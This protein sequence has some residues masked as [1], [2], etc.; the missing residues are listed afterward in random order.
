M[1]ATIADSDL[2]R[3]NRNAGKEAVVVYPELLDLVEKALAYAKLSDGAFN[4]AIGPLL[5]LWG[6]GTDEARVPSDEEIR[7]TLPL[8]SWK[9]VQVD[10]EAGTIY[11]PQPGMALDLGGIAKGYATDC[12]MQMMNEAG[13]KRALLSMGASSVSTLGEKSDGRLWRIGIQDPESAL[14]TQET[15]AYLAVLEVQDKAISTSGVYQR[16]F[17]SNGVLYHHILSSETGYPAET[18]LLSLTLVAD[19]TL[20]PAANT[21]VDALS[22]ALFVMGYER[23]VK[24]LETIPGIEALFITTDDAIHLTPG[25]EGSFS[26]N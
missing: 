2:E 3:V 22:T 10:R 12:V 17:E 16:Y 13:V 7:A 19:T 20:L 1:S 18:G 5:R 24:L 26:L 14:L 23:G 4:P 11:L 6:I 9:E 21:A 8:I 25:L 15:G